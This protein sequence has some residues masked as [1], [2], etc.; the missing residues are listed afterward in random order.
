MIRGTTPTLTLSVPGENLTGKTVE[1][2]I[3]QEGALIVKAGDALSIS[4]SS[5]GSAIAMKLTQR[6]T[7]TLRGGWANVQVRWI[8]SQGNVQATDKARVKVSALLTGSEIEYEGAG[9]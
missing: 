8:D 7:L 5:A 1:V 2:Y 4:G 6:E 3:R 9:T